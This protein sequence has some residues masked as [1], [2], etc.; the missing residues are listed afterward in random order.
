MEVIDDD[1]FSSINISKAE[2]D[3]N[4]DGKAY[5]NIFLVFIPLMIM[6]EI[7]VFYGLRWAFKGKSRKLFLPYYRI[8][9]SVDSMAILYNLMALC[10]N[11]KTL[12]LLVAISAGI[13]FT[14]T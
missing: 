10:V 8:G 9:I 13:T 5:S 7:K 4:L 11:H 2:K 14:I 12:N 1:I 3:W 6:F